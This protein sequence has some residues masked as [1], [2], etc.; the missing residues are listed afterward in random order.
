[1]TD[2][3]EPATEDDFQARNQPVIDEMAEKLVRSINIQAI[4]KF[5]LYQA[6]Q[7]PDAYN[8]SRAATAFREAE[9]DTNH[10]VDQMI[11]TYIHLFKEAEFQ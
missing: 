4:R 9:A 3:P 2:T 7:N 6:R 1:M 5:Q 10:K 11:E 8:V